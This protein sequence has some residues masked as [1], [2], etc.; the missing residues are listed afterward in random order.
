[1]YKCDECNDI[2]KQKQGQAIQV[3]AKVSK[4]EK[5][6]R[7]G[8]GGLVEPLAKQLKEQQ[9][10]FDKDEV[11]EYQQCND[12]IFTLHLSDILTYSEIEKARQ[13]LYKQILTH[14]KKKNN[15]KAC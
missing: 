7:I 10:N 15:L 1:M 11:E 6:V 2:G 4:P 12:A 3:Q 14:I 9:L 13:K 8:F 5:Q